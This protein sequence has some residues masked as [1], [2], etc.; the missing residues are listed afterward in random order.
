MDNSFSRFLKSSLSSQQKKYL[1]K[2]LAIRKRLLWNGRSRIFCISFQRTG[3]TSVHR[4]LEDHGYQVAS[5][6][7][8]LRNG[9][10]QKVFEGNYKKIFRDPE[11]ISH[12]AFQDHPWFFPEIYKIL[13]YKFP[14]SKFILLERDP[15]EWFDSMLALEEKEPGKFTRSENHAWVYGRLHEYI[16]E[17]ENLTAL[18]DLPENQQNLKR[19]HYRYHYICKNEEVKHFFRK[20]HPE[21]LFYG[22]LSDPE[23]WNDLAHFLGHNEPNS[24]PH[25]NKRQI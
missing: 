25:E 15:D 2:I 12:Q 23:L 4:F 1:L 13:Y 11:F 21:R 16:E 8:S 17:N 18:S 20:R 10:H 6:G 19:K 14:N 3:T 5:N 24:R 22:N 7:T 9:W